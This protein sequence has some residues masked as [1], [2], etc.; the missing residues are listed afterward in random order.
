MLTCVL[1]N[2]VWSCDFS[3][4]VGSLLC[5]FHRLYPQARYTVEFMIQRWIVTYILFYL[6]VSVLLVY[7]ADDPRVCARAVL[8]V[9]CCVVCH[10]CAF[11]VFIIIKKC[12][13]VSFSS[14]LFSS[15]LFSSLPMCKR[16]NW[17]LNWVFSVTKRWA[18]K[19]AESW[20]TLTQSF[21]WDNIKKTSPLSISVS[22]CSPSHVLI[23][24]GT[25]SSHSWL[26]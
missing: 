10:W 13:T 26:L 25:L 8:F 23:V 20:Q 3:G 5:E 24:V 4:L 9:S 2:K 11:I 6:G 12:S 14:L 21:Q 1:K 16:L 18:H 15:L 17:T 19:P 7:A 22:T